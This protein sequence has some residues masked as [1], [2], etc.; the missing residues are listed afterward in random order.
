MTCFSIFVLYPISPRKVI[1]NLNDVYIN[2]H[3]HELGGSCK[4]VEENKK[5][6]VYQINI[7]HEDAVAFLR[8]LLKPFFVLYIRYQYDLTLFYKNAHVQKPHVPPPR[9]D[10]L[11]KDIYWNAVQ[12]ERNM[13]DI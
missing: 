9:S 5:H 1:N 8:D 3:T 7:C 6:Y 2:R 13:L 10:K 4:K 12:C 11:L